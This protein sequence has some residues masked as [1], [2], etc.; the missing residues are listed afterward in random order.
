MKSFTF[1]L[2]TGCAAAR[3]QESQTTPQSKEVLPA[4]TATPTPFP[5]SPPASC[6][7]T[8][9]PDE[10]FAPPSPY[11]AE[12]PPQYVG[13]FWYGAPELWT[14]LR[15]DGTWNSLPHTSDGYTQKLVWW[16]Q[17]Y[18]MVAEPTPKLT[19]TG[20]RLDAPAPPLFESGATNASAELGEMM[21]I[22]VS[23][24]TLGCWE[25]KGEYKGHEL[26]FVVWV[27]P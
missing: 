14:M 9:P 21:M 19:V 20:K 12:L 24:P 7:I 10:S 13:E 8:H 22:G 25:I 2:L 1:L 6:P 3:S 16:R 5:A 26:S 15:T 18:D 4:E 17:G 11:P 27:A 23:I